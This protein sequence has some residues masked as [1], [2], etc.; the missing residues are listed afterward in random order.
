LVVWLSVCLVCVVLRFDVVD[1]GRKRRGSGRR[2]VLKYPSKPLSLRPGKVR[3]RAVSIHMIIDVIPSFE[4][5]LHL[6]P[7]GHLEHLRLAV[8]QRGRHA[9]SHWLA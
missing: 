4:A 5:H 7:W 1:G 6:A 3:V 9:A 8:R 2:R